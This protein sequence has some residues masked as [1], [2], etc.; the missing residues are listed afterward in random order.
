MQNNPVFFVF[1]ILEQIQIKVYSD[2]YN[3]SCYD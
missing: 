2:N 3:I 1:E